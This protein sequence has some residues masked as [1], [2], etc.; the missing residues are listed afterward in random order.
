MRS[1]FDAV[2]QVRSVKEQAEDVLL[3][4]IAALSIGSLSF[5]ISLL[6]LSSNDPVEIPP[7]ISENIEKGESSRCHHSS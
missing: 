1:A 6:N 3:G 7:K 2:L 4:E 5:E